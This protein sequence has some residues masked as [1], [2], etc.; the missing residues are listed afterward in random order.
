MA[1]S[2]RS[3]TVPWPKATPTLPQPQDPPPPDTPLG[4]TL[5]RAGEPLPPEPPRDDIPSDRYAR[6]AARAA[7]HAAEIC[8]SRD[9]YKE[10]CLAQE[11]DIAQLNVRL[12]AARETERAHVQKVIDEAITAQKAAE[13][14]AN[15]LRGEIESLRRQV[16]A[17]RT[18]ADEARARTAKLT[19]F[20]EL[21]RAAV[22]TT[23]GPKESENEAAPV[24]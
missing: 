24:A 12:E 22:D 18:E 6:E 23:I 14:Q 7:E 15:V 9:H 5:R 16:E 10:L 11:R 20:C 21:V 17:S 2:E 8:R 3:R 4:P 1:Q 13:E 19:A